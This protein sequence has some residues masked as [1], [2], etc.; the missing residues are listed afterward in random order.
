MGASAAYNTLQPPTYIHLAFYV[1]LFT[2]MESFLIFLLETYIHMPS[3]L[4]GFI[5]SGYIFR[6][7]AFQVHLYLEVKLGLVSGCRLRQNGCIRS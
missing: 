3:N 4:A 1:D 5:T 7:I 6:L 2:L